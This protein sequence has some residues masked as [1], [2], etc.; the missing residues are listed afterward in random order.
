VSIQYLWINRERP[1]LFSR[2]WIKAWTKRVVCVPA[3]F[4]LLI[5]RTSLK[6]KGARLGNLT[7]LSPAFFNG[8][9]KRLQ[10]GSMSSI[11]R[12]FFHLHDNILIGDHV[13]I[14]DGVTLLTASHHLDSP[15]W[16]MFA[17]SIV[18][19]DFAWIAIGAIILPGVKIGKGA[20]VGAGAVVSKDVPD[21]SIVAGNPAT[22]I[23]KKRCNN[24]TYN[25]VRFIACYEAWLGH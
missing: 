13:V 22:L 7:V 15:E 8:P 17:K 18:I 12:V 19:G 3:L 14:N 16:Q 4:K 1:R 21:F 9:L 20:V 24:L 6:I 25:P 5:R 23:N 2:R 11:G 10:I